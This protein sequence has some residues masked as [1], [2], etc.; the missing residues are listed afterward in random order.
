VRTKK[1]TLFAIITVIC[2]NASAEQNVAQ[3]G[4]GY[5]HLENTSPF[6]TDGQ[7]FYF[8]TPLQ[9]KQKEQEEEPAPPAPPAE[10]PKPEPEAPKPNPIPDGP[11]AFSAAWIRINLPKYQEAAMDSCAGG[12]TAPECRVATKA[13]MY[14]Q[15]TG[16]DMAARFAQS[17]AMV[18]VGDAFLDPASSERSSTSGRLANNSEQKKSTMEIYE[19]LSQTTGLIYIYRSDC[20]Y[21]K[22]FSPQLKQF[23]RETGMAVLPIAMDNAPPP[24]AHWD[25]WRPN[26]GLAEQLSV[27]SVPALFMLGPN[28]EIEPIT[29]GIISRDE[30]YRRTTMVGMR[31]GLI[32]QEAYQ[33]TAYAYDT[34][35]VRLIDIVDREG[36]KANDGFI[37]PEQ[38]LDFVA[39]ATEFTVKNSAATTLVGDYRK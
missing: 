2:L 15:Q 9:E 39:T 33:S 18:T 25:N 17:F 23:E 30:L 11:K 37:D 13:Y 34:K 3:A 38:I 32:S 20:P 35:D 6:K 29:L 12:A 36:F 4:E 26:N 5:E 22:K 16:L 1:T 8:Y 27:T 7:G 24:G 10:A 21:S 14:V 31:M 28:N 19:R